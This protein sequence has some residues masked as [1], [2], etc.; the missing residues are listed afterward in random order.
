MRKIGSAKGREEEEEKEP[1][2]G[3]ELMKSRFESEH[4]ATVP[5]RIKLTGVKNLWL[6]TS[7]V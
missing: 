7:S 2:P 5:S 4:A 3:G 6:D 1:H